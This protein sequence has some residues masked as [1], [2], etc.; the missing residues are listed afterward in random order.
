GSAEP[1]ENVGKPAV[2]T[3]G[4]VRSDAGHKGRP[5]LFSGAQML[6]LRP[7]GGNRNPY[8]SARGRRCRDRSRRSERI[9]ILDA[10][11]VAQ[12]LLLERLAPAVAVERKDTGLPVLA[13]V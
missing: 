10:V 7:P 8:G 5:R 3:I 11:D 13:V 12:A 1:V 4:P 9:E 6:C 2:R